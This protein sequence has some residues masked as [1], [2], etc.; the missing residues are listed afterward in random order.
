L[1]HSTSLYSAVSDPTQVDDAYQTP[2]E[3][4]R[5]PSTPSSPSMDLASPLQVQIPQMQQTLPSPSTPTTTKK[6]SA[7]AFRRPRL[8]GPLSATNVRGDSFRQD[9]LSVGFRPSPSWERGDNENLAG[10]PENITTPLNLRKKTL[11]SVP[12]LPTSPLSGPRDQGAPRS[13]SSPF[14]NLRASEEQRPGDGR[15]T[16]S[17]SS[18]EPR[19]RE[20]MDDFDYVSA[21]LNEDERRQSVVRDGATNGYEHGG[22]RFPTR[23]NG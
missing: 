3:Y 12:G 22:G 10:I 9:S 23:L 21:Y 14:P 4:L 15:M 13:V 19:P 7:A 20:S 2:P 5:N 11:P 8:Q 6:I 16:P 1:S 18:P 17:S